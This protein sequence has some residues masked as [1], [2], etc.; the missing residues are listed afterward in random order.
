MAGCKS[1]LQRTNFLVRRRLK[2]GIR[3][4][5]MRIFGLS[6]PVCLLSLLFLFPSNVFAEGGLFQAVQKGS[7]SEVGSL[8]SGGI[9]VNARDDNGLSPLMVASFL[10]N[11]DIVKLL[12]Q[13]GADVN[14]RDLQGENA[15]IKASA[16]GR[17]EVVRLL[18]ER[19]G[20][21]QCRGAT[22]Y[23]LVDGSGI[24]RQCNGGESPLGRGRGSESRGQ[25]W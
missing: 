3:V 2:I 1:R 21:R 7:P 18:L 25:R 14:A 11:V 24:Q 19:W 4:L 22:G 12:L 6:T 13:K 17:E 23:Q 8:L 10:G 15:L 5:E 16:A 9:D 20:G